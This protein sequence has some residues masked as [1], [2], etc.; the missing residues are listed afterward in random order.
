MGRIRYV[1][2][3]NPGSTSTKLAVYG[4]DILL[5]QKV[6]RHTHEELA[7]YPTI[8]DQIPYRLELIS[9]ALLEMDFQKPLSAV[10]GRGGLTH[11]LPGGVYKVDHPMIY[12][13]ENATRQHAS[14]LGAILAARI[15]Y[16]YTDCIPLIADPV[17]V[18][19]M[20]EKAHISGHPDMPRLSIFHALNQKAVARQYCRSIGLLYDELNII[21]CH[22]G[23]GV[24]VGAHEKGR[25]ID[26]NNALDGEG[27]FSP[28][29][30]GT[31][32]AGQLIDYIFKKQLTYTQA[33]K[34]IVGQGG[35]MAHF[36]TTN[37]PDILRKVRDG[38]HR[39]ATVIAAMEYSIA[40]YIGM[41]AVALM[42]K[43][44]AII[45]TGGIANNSTITENI[46]LQVQWIAPVHVLPG[47]DEFEA[48]RVNAFRVLDNP[49][50]AKEY[51][52]ADKNVANSS[53][54]QFLK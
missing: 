31:L 48:M 16:R 46:K 5:H 15:A 27:P 49:S 42:G 17:V 13:L 19:E 30:S 1:L 24:S 2:A 10:I 39:A 18:D 36:G 23:G 51:I 7:E 40:K 21:V 52:P 4:E 3:I 9:N 25:V 28:E 6:I 34:L 54:H 50:E 32:P 11:P 47:E 12:D 53:V 29:R 44:D 26:V 38:D 22:M 37:V 14:N 35:L 33:K 8:K 41:C 43:V 45:L 20:T